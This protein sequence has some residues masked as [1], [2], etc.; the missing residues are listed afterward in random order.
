MEKFSGIRKDLGINKPSLPHV[1]V[2]RKE[3]RGSGRLR[4]RPDEIWNLQTLHVYDADNGIC[5]ISRQIDK[6]TNEIPVILKVLKT[7]D[8]RG[9]LVTFDALHTQKT[10][11]EIIVKGKGYFMGGLKGNQK[12]LNEEARL[13]FD[14]HYLKQVTEDPKRYYKITEKAHSHVET[15]EFSL[16]PVKHSPGSSFDQWPDIRTVV[17]YKKTIDICTGDGKKRTE[18]RYYVTNLWDAKN[19]RYGIRSHWEVANNF[20]W[21]LDVKFGDDSNLTVNHKAS[22]NLSLLKNMVLSLYKLL[23]PFEKKRTSLNMI[24]VDFSACFEETMQKLLTL[25][26]DKSL[27]CALG[28]AAHKK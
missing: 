24:R 12:M 10:T 18:I 6:K 20:Y 25:C 21:Q 3:A 1:C 8:L 19:C 2:D 13:F 5:M 9:V 4:D 26:D 27:K 11:V 28:A 17:R 22:G 14:E 15:R 16:A 7:M 23:Q